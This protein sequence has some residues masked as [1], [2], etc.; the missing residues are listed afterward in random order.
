[1][2]ALLN[3][4]C[5]YFCSLMISGWFKRSLLASFRVVATIGIRASGAIPAPRIDVGEWLNLAAEIVKRDDLVHHGCRLRRTGFA[6]DARR[7][8]DHGY[9]WRHF[10]N[11]HRTGADTGTVTH[12]D[13]AEHD[14]AGADQHTVSDLGMA[15]LVGLARTAKG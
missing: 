9:P 3:F 10:A 1:M 11:D 12:P 5:R 14:R 6:D 2:P 13:I 7:N 8:S 15:V 4:C